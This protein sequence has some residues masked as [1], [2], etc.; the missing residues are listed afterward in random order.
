M[1]VADDLSSLIHHRLVVA[2]YTFV[3]RPPTTGKK[4][5]PTPPPPRQRQQRQQQHEDFGGR[6]GEGPAGPALH[7][8]RD[9]PR[10]QGRC[11][12]TT[13]AAAC[14]VCVECYG[15]NPSI[16]PSVDPSDAHKLSRPIRPPHHLAMLQGPSTRSSAWGISTRGHPTTPRPSRTTCA[17]RP[18]PRS[19]DRIGHWSSTPMG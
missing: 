5:A 3:P 18:P 15:T 8:C 1:C 12:Y 6:R 7:A 13:A 9:A 4:P 16:R 2:F 14:P 17:V 11:V 19:I 10:E